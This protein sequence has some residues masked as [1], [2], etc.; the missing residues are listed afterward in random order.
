MVRGLAEPCILVRLIAPTGN[1]MGA[2]R[3]ELAPGTVTA[4][5]ELQGNKRGLEDGVVPC[6]SEGE[7]QIYQGTGVAYCPGKKREKGK[8]QDT[9]IAYHPV[10]RREKGK[11]QATGIAY[12]PMER[13][14]KELKTV[15]KETQVCH[16]CPWMAGLAPYILLGPPRV[17]RC[18][19]SGGG[20]RHLPK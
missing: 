11:G 2:V 8:C 10:E 17:M 14:Q 6:Q 16:I 13:R 4:G 19:S 7:K 12:C 5:K 18:A 9:R 15:E 3:W 20:S 1:G